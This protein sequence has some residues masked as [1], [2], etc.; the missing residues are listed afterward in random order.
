MNINNRIDKYLNEAGDPAMK[1][2]KKAYIE[3]DKAVHHAKT[4][5]G[6][7]DPISSGTDIWKELTS[8]AN[9]MNKLTIKLKKQKAI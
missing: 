6:Q 5:A 4:M 2:F 3:M 8:F 1:E 7:L 9:Q